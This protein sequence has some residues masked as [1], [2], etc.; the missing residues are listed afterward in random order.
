MGGDEVKAMATLTRSSIALYT[1]LVA[2]GCS[3][4]FDLDLRSI[5]DGPDTTEAARMATAPRPTPDARG[6]I[7][8][9]TY[10]VAI[11]RRGDTVSDVAGRLGV[12]AA[13]LASFNGIRDGVPLRSGETLVLPNPVGASGVDVAGLAGDAIER[14]E[15]SGTQAPLGGQTASGIEPIR[16]RVQPGET[17]FSIARIYAVTP[18]A[19]SEW[20]GLGD[21]YAVRPGEI[22]LIPVAVETATLAPI[23]ETV[24]PG[25]GSV[26]P[27]PPSAAAPLPEVDVEPEPKPAPASP[28]LA[29]ERTDNS[30]LLLPVNGR[31]VR[32]YEK[33]SNEGIGIA[34]DAGTPVMAADGGTVAA[35]TRDTDQVPILVLRHEDNL[36]TVYAGVDSLSVEKGDNVSRG[37]VIGAVR[38]GAN[39]FLHFEVRDGFESVDPMP[40]LN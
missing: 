11:A 32:D 21:D 12:P 33:G 14:S 25:T 27:E 5:G 24:A 34:A 36:L 39:P 29:E 9:P 1:L 26:A 7:T 3:D 35:I 28:N 4:G 22:L 2:A 23:E 20:N 17:A 10:Q 19:L 8:Y 15:A 37:Q 40:Y 16:H 30:R 31:I 38:E 13:E 18:Q 6:L